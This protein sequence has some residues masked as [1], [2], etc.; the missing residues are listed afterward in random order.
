MVFDVVFDQMLRVRMGPLL[1]LTVF[2]VSALCVGE[3]SGSV[4]PPARP[5]RARH[6]CNWL[7]L[8]W[9]LQPPSWFVTQ[10]SLCSLSSL[11]SLTSHILPLTEWWEA[12][13]DSPAEAQLQTKVSVFQL[14]W[15][16]SK[17]Q[18]NNWLPYKRE[19]GS[20]GHLVLSHTVNCK[21]KWKSAEWPNSIRPQSLWLLS[22]LNNE[23][24]WSTDT[25]V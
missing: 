22:E 9:A 17:W 4:E 1:V 5:G 13:P 24:T 23:I 19:L 15:I 18:E 2:W 25:S 21:L 20:T 3:V 14:Q 11:R 16:S 8:G 6:C 10:R 12:A 7:E